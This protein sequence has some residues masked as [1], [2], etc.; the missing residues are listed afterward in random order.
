MNYLTVSNVCSPSPLRI[1]LAVGLSCGFALPAHAQIFRAE[2]RLMVE[3]RNADFAVYGGGD[4]G[5]CGTWCTAADYARRVLG[6]SATDRIFVKVPRSGNVVV[7]SMSPD[8]LAPRAAW[9]AELGVRKA[10]A[11]LLVGH[12]VQFCADTKVINP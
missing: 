9:I 10:G 6:A 7:F 12:A 1:L 4:H 2:N 8:G 11:N 3:P 5:A